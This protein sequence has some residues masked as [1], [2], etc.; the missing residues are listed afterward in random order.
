[1]MAGTHDNG[2][3]FGFD[4]VNMWTEPTLCNE[5]GPV[6]HQREDPDDQA[7]CECE[8]RLLWRMGSLVYCECECH[9]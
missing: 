9:R 8:D 6:E 2:R 5:C 3:L 1:M 4:G 7:H